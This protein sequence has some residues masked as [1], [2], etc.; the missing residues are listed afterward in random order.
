MIEQAINLNL[1]Q[2]SL[3]PTSNQGMVPLYKLHGSCNYL[4][5]ISGINF[6][7]CQFITGTGGIALDTTIRVVSPAEAIQFC[8]EQNSV[9]PV[10]AMYTTGKEIKFCA[11]QVLEQQKTWQQLTL[12]AK[13]NFVIGLAITEEDCH[14]WDYLAD[15]PARLFYVGKQSDI[16]SWAERRKKANVTWLSEKFVDAM[17]QILENI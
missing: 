3:T 5:K 11:R 16:E 10:I 2:V 6:N 13:A 7:D 4:P 15:S 12:I 9:A 8:R 14:I 17:P 1:R